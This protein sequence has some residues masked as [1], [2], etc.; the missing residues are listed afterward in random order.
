METQFMKYWAKSIQP[1]H[2][3]ERETEAQSSQRQGH[4]RWL[5]RGSGL[6]NPARVHSGLPSPAPPPG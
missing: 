6:E 1:A 3:T 4:T 2:F 5:T